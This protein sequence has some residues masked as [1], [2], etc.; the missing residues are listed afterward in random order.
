M[1]AFVLNLLHRLQK[2]ELLFGRWQ[3]DALF[4]RVVL[5][6]DRRDALPETWQTDDSNYWTKWVSLDRLTC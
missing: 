2:Q 6:S 1:Y 4:V 3:F 5:R